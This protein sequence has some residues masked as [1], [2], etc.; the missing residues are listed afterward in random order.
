MQSKEKKL[1]TQ[2]VL[3]LPLGLTA[4]LWAILSFPFEKAGAGLILLSVVTVFSGSYLRIQIPRTKLHLTISDALIFLTLLVYGGAA[5]TILAALEAGFSSFNLRTKGVGMS[6]RT[7]LV[8]VLVAV[9]SVFSTAIVVLFLFPSTDPILKGEDTTLFAS[10]IGIMALTQFLVNSVFASNFIA[11]K[12]DRTLWEV[13]NEYCLSLL[14]MFCSG[15]V[16]AGLAAKALQKFEVIQLSLVVG[17]FGLVY[18]TYKRY[19]DDVMETAARAEQAERTRAEQ[20]ESHLS[21]LENYVGELEKSGEALRES[22]E[23]FRHAAYHDALTRLPNRNFV[24]KTLKQLLEEAQT[25]SAKK[26]AVLF[27]NLNRFRL[28]NESLSHATGDRII[29]EIGKVI[30]ETLGEGEMVGHFGGDEFAVILPQ[31]QDSSAAIAIAGE[32]AE[33]IA[34]PVRFR[35]RE[36]YTTVSIGIAVGS[37]E[38]VYAED[39]LRD[40]DIA[41]YHAKDERKVSV[42]FDKA[43][44][45]QAVERQQV[46]TDLRYAIVCNELEVFYQPIVRLEDAT[47]RGFEAL[48]RWN[49][50]TRGFVKPNEFIPIAETTGLII[51][52][53]LQILKSSCTQLVDWEK[54]HPTA[55]ALMMSVNIS[56]THFADSRLVDQVKAIIEET[57]IRPSSLKLE[58]TEGAVMENA[59]A[60]IETLKRI[61]SAGVSISI[62]DFGTGYSSLS[63]LH[64]F[65]LDYLKIDQSFVNSMEEGSENLEIIRTIIALAKALKLRII[66][67]GIETREQLEKLRSLGCDYGQG[68]LFSRPLPASFIEDL[69]SDADMSKSL[70][71]ISYFADQMSGVELTH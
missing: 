53:T 61:K 54:Q 22:R 41:M 30:S 42:V 32:I 8:N 43:M 64:K 12:T 49:H 7:M 66:A 67:E 39:I 15:A 38:Y 68:Y 19:L 63:Y 27:L 16:M 60:A 46:E 23:K 3:L 1:K 9:V 58:I 70:P 34:E 10:L 13:W 45:V 26:F 56:V 11:I 17:F 55:G 40:A 36:V 35:N 59:E 24:I 20:P 47:L 6:F 28:I 2:L 31:C 21:E 62:D 71:G 52:M 57:G 4:I 14:V 65:P 33:R 25:D 18:I 37:G 48:I 5:A 51:P 29:R 44:R 50:P 69:F